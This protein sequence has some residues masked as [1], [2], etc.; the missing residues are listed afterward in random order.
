MHKDNNCDK[1]L[2]KRSIQKNNFAKLQADINNLKKKARK[3]VNFKGATSRIT[4]LN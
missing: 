4:H 2:Y 1:D 3:R